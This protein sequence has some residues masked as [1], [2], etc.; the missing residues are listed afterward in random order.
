MWKRLCLYVANTVLS[1]RGAGDKNSS[2]FVALNSIQTFTE[3]VLDVGHYLKKSLSEVTVCSSRRVS[4]FAD[5]SSSF[6]FLP[7]LNFPQ[8]LMQP[9]KRGKK[10]LSTDEKEKPHIGLGLHLFASLAWRNAL[11]G[12]FSLHFIPCL[13]RFGSGC[14]QAFQVSKL[15]PIIHSYRADPI[16]LSARYLLINFL[17]SFPFAF[18]DGSQNLTTFAHIC[19]PEI[20]L[21]WALSVKVFLHRWVSL[22]LN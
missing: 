5:A 21:Y 6:P 17:V 4:I 14:F 7:L 20:E 15:P 10:D 9:M 2:M 1:N 19:P 18:P 11:F 13:G 8:F 16:V 3:G 22:P 12:A